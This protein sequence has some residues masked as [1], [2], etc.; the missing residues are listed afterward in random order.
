MRNNKPLTKEQKQ[1]IQ[2]FLYYK[3]NNQVNELLHRTQHSHSV[4]IETNF[5]SASFN[6]IRVS[7]LPRD[8]YWAWSQSSAKRTILIDQTLEITLKKVGTRTKKKTVEQTPSFKL[9][10]YTIRS[11]DHPSEFYFYWCEKGTGKD[12]LKQDFL[13]ETIITEIGPICP[14]DV[15]T[16]SLSFLL[17]FVDQNTGRELGW[18]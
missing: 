8:G 2:V 15:S 17:P 16:D 1:A 6:A 14:S 18:C 10:I 4:S 5:V 3:N 12:S 9:W 7:D 11:K 13:K